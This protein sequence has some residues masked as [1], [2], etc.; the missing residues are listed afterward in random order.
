M[1]NTRPIHDAPFFSKVSLSI[2]A[3]F[4][5][6]PIVSTVFIAFGFNVFVAHAIVL[7]ISLLEHNDDYRK[8]ACVVAG[9]CMSPFVLASIGVN[10]DYIPGIM[11]VTSLTLAVYIVSLMHRFTATVDGYREGRGK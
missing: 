4:L 5:I 11:A 1:Y 7:S 3:G 8:Q 6:Y 2:I 9:Y 10:I